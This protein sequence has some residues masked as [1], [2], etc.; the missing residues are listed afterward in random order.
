M[1]DSEAVSDVTVESQTVA[2]PRWPRRWRRTIRSYY[3]TRHRT[4]RHMTEPRTARASAALSGMLA[5]LLAAAGLVV[6]FGLPTD[7]SAATRLVSDYL[8][9]LLDGD[10]D[11]ALRIADAEPRPDTDDFLTDAT[12]RSDW[13]IDYLAEVS[14][15]AIQESFDGPFDYASTVRVRISDESGRWTQGEFRVT[16]TDE[17]PPRIGNPFVSVDFAGSHAPGFLDLNG[18]VAAMSP[19]DKRENRT[20]YP[21]F[22]GSYQLYADSR[23][24][25][26]VNPGRA[27]LLPVSGADDVKDVPVEFDIAVSVTD[28][29]DKSVQ[30]ALD[31]LLDTCVES[32]EL[33]PPDCPFTAE[34]SLRDGVLDAGADQFTDVTD[35]AWKL[36]KRPRVRLHSEPGDGK[37]WLSPSNDATVTLTGTGTPRYADDEKPRKFTVDCPVDVAGLSIVL[38]AAKGFTLTAS[39]SEYPRGECALRD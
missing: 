16:W 9:A 35:L 5:A 2:A 6:F 24:L 12:L 4:A 27:L 10:S 7:G 8:N 38:T 21:V 39:E 1:S 26:P 28:K 31:Q 33:A 32:T 36:E 13:R 37:L 23:D 19:Q 29:A 20:A 15:S 30:R 11:K 17:Q 18:T 3:R 25:L 34:Y 14:T 22:P